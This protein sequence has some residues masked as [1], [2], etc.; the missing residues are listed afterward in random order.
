MATARL[1]RK[2]LASENP[3]VRL[4]IMKLDPD[5]FTTIDGRGR[6]LTYLKESPFGRLPVP[7]ACSN[8]ALY[9]RELHWHRGE[10]AGN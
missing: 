10:S 2:P 5:D 4:L 6:L 1:A 9:D 3:S 8:M 7:N